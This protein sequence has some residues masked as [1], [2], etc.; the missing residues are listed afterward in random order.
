M[1][2]WEGGEDLAD[3]PQH[4]IVHELLERF[5][6][7]AELAAM[8]SLYLASHPAEGGNS[9]FLGEN[10]RDQRLR[11]VEGER[12]GRGRGRGRGREME[13]EIEDWWRR[14]RRREPR[15]QDTAVSRRRTA[16]G[17]DLRDESLA[18]EKREELFQVHRLLILLILLE[19]PF[20]HGM[21]ALLLQDQSGP[22]SSS[23]LSVTSSLTRCE[24][25]NCLEK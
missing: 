3:L 18:L 19:Q 11:G 9:F 17:T 23:L 7:D 24:E 2:V 13:G 5:G 4:G 21:V 25:R 15:K 12:G 14:G 6:V 16:G 1:G 8:V 20:P 22:P 10:L